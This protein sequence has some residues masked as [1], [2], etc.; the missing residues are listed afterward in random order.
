MRRTKYNYES[1]SNKIKSGVDPGITVICWLVVCLKVVMWKPN[2][3]HNRLS[4]FWKPFFTDNRNVNIILNYRW[5]PHRP[6]LC[7]VPCW[8]YL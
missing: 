7:K 1:T 4:I 2:L 6:S 5:T 8:R 3:F